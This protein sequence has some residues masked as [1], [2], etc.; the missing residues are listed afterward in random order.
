MGPK[1]PFLT[2]GVMNL[3]KVSD[4]SQQDQAEFMKMGLGDLLKQPGS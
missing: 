4:I 3:L 1:V 2:S